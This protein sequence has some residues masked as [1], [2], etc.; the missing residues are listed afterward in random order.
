M[1]ASTY[2]LWWVCKLSLQEEGQEAA[3]SPRWTWPTQ[4]ET[5]VE[6]A[7]EG[8]ER[9]TERKR[10]NLMNNG[11]QNDHLSHRADKPDVCSTLHP[12]LA[13]P[14]PL[15]TTFIS[16]FWSTE[17]PSFI[18]K[19]TEKTQNLLTYCY[20]YGCLIYAFACALH[21]CLLHAEARGGY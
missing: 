11:C 13:S 9:R 10:K 2:R 14:S 12:A 3:A 15:Q 7:K 20:V 8:G 5:L 18:L 1:H 19:K 6:T 16:H 21:V 4:Q 17:V